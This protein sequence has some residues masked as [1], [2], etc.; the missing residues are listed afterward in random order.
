MEIKKYLNSSSDDHF[1]FIYF[2]GSRICHEHSHFLH[3]HTYFYHLSFLNLLNH[4]YVN[5]ILKVVT[6]VIL[7]AFIKDDLSKR[8]V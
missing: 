2:F 5:I 4:S 7:V 3:M 8:T 1:S 6:S